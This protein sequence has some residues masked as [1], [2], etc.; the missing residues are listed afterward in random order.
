MRFGGGGGRITGSYRE[1]SQSSA[2]DAQREGRT[3]AGLP[4]TAKPDGGRNANIATVRETAGAVTE[5]SLFNCGLRPEVGG[6]FP[7]EAWI[8]KLCRID[9]LRWSPNVTRADLGK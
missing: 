2:R 8:K 9:F 6:E 4:T 1:V 5:Q 3:A 7:F